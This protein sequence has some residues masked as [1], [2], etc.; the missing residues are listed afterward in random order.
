MS[1]PLLAL[2]SDIERKW[3]SVVGVEP[4]TY[5]AQRAREESDIVTLEQVA[6]GARAREASTQCAHLAARGKAWQGKRPMVDYVTIRS[7]APSLRCAHLRALVDEETARMRASLEAALE[8]AGT[9]SVLA[10]I[11]ELESNGL[12]SLVDV[13]VVEQCSWRA[14]PTLDAWQQQAKAQHSRLLNL[15]SPSTRAEQVFL[16]TALHSSRN[17]QCLACASTPQQRAQLAI[18][19]QQALPGLARVLGQ[20]SEALRVWTEACADLVVQ[21]DRD[22]DAAVFSAP[23]PVAQR[24]RFDAAVVSVFALCERPPARVVNALLARLDLPDGVHEGLLACNSLD[25]ILARLDDDVPE[26]TRALHLFAR[27]KEALAKAIVASDKLLKDDGRQLVL[28]NPVL[29]SELRLM[30]ASEL[31]RKRPLGV[32]D[33]FEGEA[34]FSEHIAGLFGGGA[35]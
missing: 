14:A 5:A 10:A 32:N 9:E 26:R 34:S 31:Q 18:E 19:L 16:A 28:V 25:F 30:C 24:D 12:E 17:P 27:R 4:R 20:S 7:L 6:Q 11:A 29:R 23:P 15:L 33:S 21:A 3:T 2:L 35:E 8:T 13:V 22:L 1:A